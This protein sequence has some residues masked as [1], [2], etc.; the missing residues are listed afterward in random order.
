MVDLNEKV[1]GMQMGVA[2]DVLGGLQRG[3]CDVA[4][5]ALVKDFVHGVQGGHV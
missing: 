3:E 2:G 4:P 1:A 5:L